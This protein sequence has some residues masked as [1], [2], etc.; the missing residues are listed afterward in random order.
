MIGMVLIAFLALGTMWSVCVPAFEKPD[1]VHHFAY[2]Q[3]L[4]RERRLPVQAREPDPFLDAELQ[5]PPLYYLVA[6]ALYDSGRAAGLARTD[7][8]T[9]ESRW[10]R[11]FMGGHMAPGRE[12][13]FFAHA[14]GEWP[15][16]DVLLVRALSPPFS[17]TTWS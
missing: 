9:W 2:V 12:P 4:A 15:P 10:N 7:L 8:R 6:A 14:A 5:Q 11:L 1:E 13:N 3:F 17:A 16:A